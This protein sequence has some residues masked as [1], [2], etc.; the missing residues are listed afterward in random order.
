MEVS[1]HA[2]LFTFL[3]HS[4]GKC[5]ISSAQPHMVAYIGADL[6]EAPLRLIPLIEL[7]FFWVPDELGSQIVL[8][9]YPED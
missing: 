7:K 5:N 4:I 2:W 1:L 9:I 6:K 3:V 8:R